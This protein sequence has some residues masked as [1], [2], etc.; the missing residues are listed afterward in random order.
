MLPRLSVLVTLLYRPLRLVRTVICA[1]ES[2][3]VAWGVKSPARLRSP[4]DSIHELGT[5][6]AVDPT[7]VDLGGADLDTQRLQ[8]RRDQRRVYY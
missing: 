8:Q 5:R 3:G 2:K 7:Q 4:V 1:A 6:I